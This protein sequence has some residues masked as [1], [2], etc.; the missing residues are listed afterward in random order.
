MT[1][2]DALRKISALL[3]KTIENGATQAEAEA[4]FSKAAAIMDEYQITN[5][6]LGGPESEFGAGNL[7][8]GRTMSIGQNTALLVLQAA[9][10]VK[11][12]VLRATG[13]LHSMRNVKIL[14]F[15]DAVA[16]QSA[17]WAFQ[18]LTATFANLWKR[19][20][21]PIRS[22]EIRQSYFRGLAIG[23]I[24]KIKSDRDQR[25]QD[26][27]GTGIVLASKAKKLKIAFYKTFGETKTINHQLDRRHDSIEADDAFVAGRRD[28]RQIN[29]AR[30]ISP[31]QSARSI[32][33][34]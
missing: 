10:P 5:K 16:C 18:F 24:S 7:F 4:A 6:D 1:R 2:D 32:T 28:G 34:A 15:G 19:Y 29:L 23:M 31:H 20:K 12:L 9:F 17:A 25:N 33:S 11:V 22:A 27:P 21:P 13:R 8:E 30:P 26:Q 14:I 3:A